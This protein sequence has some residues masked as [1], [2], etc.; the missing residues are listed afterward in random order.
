MT[1]AA[2]LPIERPRRLHLD[3][4]LPAL[5][6]PRAT[7]AAIATAARAVWLTPLLLLTLS[8]LLVVALAGPIKL[9]AA[10][11][12]EVRLPP[13][14]Q[15]YTPEQQAQYLQA[16]AATSGPVF[17]Y[18]FP[19]ILAVMRVWLGWLVLGGI[20]HLVLTLMGGR[21]GTLAALNV[22]AWA[23]LPFLL[24]D[25]V[26]AGFML[27]SG[28]LI[29]SPGLVGFAPA[30]QGWDTAI[31]TE[32]LSRIDIYGLW[33]VLLLFFGVR[34]AGGLLPRQVV[35]GLFLALTISMALQILPGVLG[36]AM[37]GLTIVRPFLF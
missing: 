23:S 14:F 22:V 15:W 6:R 37:T 9:A 2:T 35:V 20:L 5:F 13:D 19:A 21:G 27:A 26:R 33:F 32:V 1:D 18:V 7:F 17:I 29:N 16:Q 25:L 30:G 12:G 36:R 3:W 31:F 10:A 4:I 8:A 28:Q 24:R 11:S 34:A